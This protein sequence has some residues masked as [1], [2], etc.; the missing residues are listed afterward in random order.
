MKMWKHFES[1]IYK[2]KTNTKRC[3]FSAGLFQFST[4]LF[5]NE[6]AFIESGNMFNEKGIS[7]EYYTKTYIIQ[8]YPYFNVQERMPSYIPR[9]VEQ[10]NFLY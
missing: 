6:N 3:G 7:H 5:V 2:S 8:L 10:C 4:S 9:K 1:L